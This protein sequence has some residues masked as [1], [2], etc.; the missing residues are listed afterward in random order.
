MY[1]PVLS[2]CLAS[3]RL[4]L[5]LPPLT[6]PHLVLPLLTSLHLIAHLS[7]RSTLRPLPRFVTVWLPLLVFS[8]TLSSPRRRNLA[9][10]RLA[11]PRF[12]SSLVSSRLAL[13]RLVSSRFALPRIISSHFVSP[14]HDSTRLHS[15]LSSPLPLLVFFSTELLRR[16]HRAVF[17]AFVPNH[18]NLPIIRSLYASFLF[19]CYVS[20][21][22]AITPIVSVLWSMCLRVVS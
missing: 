19:V 16:S 12:T 15:V 17:T 7:T 1:S 21:H 10:P 4:V 3:S 8:S 13:P 22:Y 2:F 14:C 18:G 20:L 5:P 9:S 6:S 11:S